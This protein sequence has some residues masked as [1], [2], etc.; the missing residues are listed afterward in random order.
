MSTNAAKIAAQLGIYIDMTPE[1][2]RARRA[3]MDRVCQWDTV[4]MIEREKE[5]KRKRKK[6]I[7]DP[8]YLKMRSINGGLPW[9]PQD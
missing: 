1:E 9:F 4:L 3:E 2:R 7:N 8:N 5:R 6:K